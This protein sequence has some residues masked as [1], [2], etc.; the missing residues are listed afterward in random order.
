[1][2]DNEIATLRFSLSP[3]LPLS[4][5]RF[6]IADRDQLHHSLRTSPQLPARG[7]NRIA[8]A[9]AEVDV[10]PALLRAVGETLAARRWTASRTAN[11]PQGCTE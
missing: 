7:V 11:R 6:H 3:G 8:L 2:G 9:V 1:M 5:S 4:L 10:D